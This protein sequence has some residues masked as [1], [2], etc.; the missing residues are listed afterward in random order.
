MATTLDNGSNNAGCDILLK[1]I[2]SKKIKVLEKMPSLKLMSTAAQICLLH[3]VEKNEVEVPSY[4]VQVSEE[5][6]EHEELKFLKIKFAAVFE[7]PTELP[8]SRGVLDHRIN[9]EPGSG[10]SIS[11]RTD[12]L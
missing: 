10:L 2:P 3:V 12:I 11:D 1:G 4:L 6:R 7:E 5:V 8:P 9:L